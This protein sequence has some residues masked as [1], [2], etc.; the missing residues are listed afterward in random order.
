MGCSLHVEDLNTIHDLARS[1]KCE[2]TLTLR[3][4]SLYYHDKTSVTVRGAP[5]FFDFGPLLESKP[6]LPSA[7]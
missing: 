6:S 7:D 4:K 5:P 1:L 3:H 2:P